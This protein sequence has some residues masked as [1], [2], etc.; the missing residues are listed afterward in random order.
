MSMPI[1]ATKGEKMSKMNTLDNC[2]IQSYSSQ[3]GELQSIRKRKRERK[4]KK[5]KE[6]KVN[7]QKD[8]RKEG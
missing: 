5:R 4:R 2:E 1:A 7:E 6:E 8:L 3:K